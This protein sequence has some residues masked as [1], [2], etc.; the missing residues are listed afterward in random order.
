MPMTF[1]DLTVDRYLEMTKCKTEGTAAEKRERAA[2]KSEELGDHV[3]AWEIRT[4][5]PWNEM[6]CAEAEELVKVY[7]QL[8]RNPGV[9]SR[10]IG[11]IY[12]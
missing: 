12:L 6:T 8:M 3:Q 2:T 10:L 11:S 1:D 7:P 9:R 5:R 4:G